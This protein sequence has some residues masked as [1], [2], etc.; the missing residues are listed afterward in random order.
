VDNTRLQAD[1]LIGQLQAALTELVAI[2]ALQREHAKAFAVWAGVETD[3]RL[4]E[5]DRLASEIA[6]R[7]PLA[8]A[9]ARRALGMPDAT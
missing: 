4:R 7:R 3:D 5:V 6:R 2:E 8:W 1:D 9:A